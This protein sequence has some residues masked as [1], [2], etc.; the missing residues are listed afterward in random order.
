MAT[1]LNKETVIIFLIIFST[2][3]AG[4]LDE[5]EST[6]ETIIDWDDGMMYIES[7]SGHEDSREFIIGSGNNN[8]T[9]GNS[10]W[11]VFGNEEGGNCCEHYL[12]GTK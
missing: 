9:W 8:E 10:S 3:S 1:I 11:A 7:P 4:C 5:G 12:A 6:E 2:F